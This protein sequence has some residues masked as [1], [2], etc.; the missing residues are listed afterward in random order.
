MIGRLYLG[1]DIGGTKI[2]GV[3]WNGKRVV[4][5][6]E[7]PTP[8]NRKKFERS[9]GD[10][11]SRLERK[12]G[13]RIRD[14][15]IGVAGVVLGTTVRFSPNIPYLRQFNFRIVFP[16]QRLRVDNDARAFARAE[17]THGAGRGA[18]RILA[19]TIGSG[20]GR[21]YG[22]QGRIIRTKRF[23]YPEAWERRYQHIRDGGNSR[24]LTAFLGEKLVPIVRRHPAE[25][26]VLGGGVLN[27]PGFLR[28]LKAELRRRRVSQPVRHSRLGKNAAAIGAAMLFTPE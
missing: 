10:I 15:G 25:V 20:I 2:R 4:A 27:R 14:V 16:S 23:E 7:F 3:V 26:L 24:T 13:Q 18:R 6:C 5:W 17:L 19:F 28:G 8:R 11:A 12:S 21:A 1:I 22:G 9:I